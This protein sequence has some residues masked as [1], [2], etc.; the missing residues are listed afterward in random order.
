MRELE[1]F[2]TMT[3]YLRREGYTVVQ[4]NR[5]KKLGP[6]IVAERAGRKLVIQ[7][8]GDSVAIK[9]DWDKGLGQLLDMMNDDKADYA[10]A[11]SEKYGR[12]ARKFPKYA[13]EKLQLT[14]F[15]VRDDGKVVKI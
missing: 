6:D 2:E 10:M 1:M 3:G 9:T 13:K 5:G 7:M 12:L 4:V 15:I 11:V 8:K 14:F